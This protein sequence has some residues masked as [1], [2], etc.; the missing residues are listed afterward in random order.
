LK[1]AA[2]KFNILSGLHDCELCDEESPIRID[3]LEGVHGGSRSAPERY[4]LLA[5][6]ARCM[7]RQL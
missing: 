6:N 5:T 4:V 2:E 3:A 1:R 7:P